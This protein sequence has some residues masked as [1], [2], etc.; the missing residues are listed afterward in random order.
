MGTAGPPLLHL[1]ALVPVTWARPRPQPVKI[2][3]IAYMRE[4][5][6]AYA[7]RRLGETIGVRQGRQ[8]VRDRI[9]ALRSER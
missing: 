7:A 4:Q 3:L 9:S 6:V 5:L 8:P 2:G 1:R